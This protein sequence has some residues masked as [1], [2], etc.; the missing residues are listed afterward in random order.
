LDKKDLM[1]FSFNAKYGL[2]EKVSTKG[3]IYNN[4]IFLLQMLTKKLQTSDIFS[5]DLNLNKWVNLA[6]PNRVK[7]VFDHGLFSEVDKIDFKENNVYK[8]L[9]NFI[10]IGFLCSKDS[11]NK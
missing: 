6:F 4:D 5:R 10:C 11:P 7:D 3:H 8:F 2:G 1:K 9:I